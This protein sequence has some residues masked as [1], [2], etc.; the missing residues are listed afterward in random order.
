MKW[1]KLLHL[2]FG[3]LLLLIP[4]QLIIFNGFNPAG[5]LANLWLVP[6][7]SCL[8]IPL[9]LLIFLLPFDY[10]QSLLFEFIDMVLSMSL[11][12]LPFLAQFWLKGEFIS[13][14]LV[15]I[16]G[17]LPIIYILVGTVHT[18]I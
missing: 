15:A 7:I 18:T 3:L 4:I 13:P 8:I 10:L 6:L 1:I 5:L 17:L 14:W 2:Q 9:L 11:S 12:P 16:S